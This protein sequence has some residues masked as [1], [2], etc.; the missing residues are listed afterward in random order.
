[1]QVTQSSEDDSSL[2]SDLEGDESIPYEEL[3][4]VRNFLSK[5]VV[6]SEI[7]SSDQINLKLA[8][9]ALPPVVT[10]NNLFKVE[11]FNF[12]ELQKSLIAFQNDDMDE[13][14]NFYDER[15]KGRF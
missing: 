1:M 12:M 13:L 4:I 9:K 6:V 11:L 7:S 5:F 15:N 10:Q 3:E 2:E 8:L 14:F